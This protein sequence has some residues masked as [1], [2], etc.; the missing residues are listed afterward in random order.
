MKGDEPHQQ[1]TDIS[2]CPDSYINRLKH[3]FL[4]YKALPDEKNTSEITAIYGRKE[5]RQVINRAKDDYKP[6][7]KIFVS[8]CLSNTHF[9]NSLRSPINVHIN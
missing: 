9:F 6:H 8:S 2:D 1:W 4:T 3:Y 5:A 7:L